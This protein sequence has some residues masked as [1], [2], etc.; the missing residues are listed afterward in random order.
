MHCEPSNISHEN[1]KCTV[2]KVCDIK[3]KSVDP[4]HVGTCVA[5]KIIPKENPE[6]HVHMSA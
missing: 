2:K 3:W 6:K 5:E 4:V 1:K